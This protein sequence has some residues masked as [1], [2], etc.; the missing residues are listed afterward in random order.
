MKTAP[1]VVADRPAVNWAVLIARLVLAVIFLA[2]GSQK[3]FGAFGGFGVAGTVKFM[4]SLAYL[5]IAAEFFGGLALLVGLLSRFSAFWLAAEMIG[6]IATVHGKNG[7]FLGHKM[8]FEYNISLIGLLLVVL[9]IGPGRF[10][11]ARL[12]PI[13]DRVRRWVE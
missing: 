8:G 5:V 13:S 6:A 1:E 11:F 2:H 3:L 7:F 9:I 12:V 4:G 10:S